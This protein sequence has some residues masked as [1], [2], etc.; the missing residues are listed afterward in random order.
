MMTGFL[1][2]RHL[3][4]LGLF[5]AFFAILYSALR[6]RSLK[7]KRIVLAILSFAGIPAI[8]WYPIAYG[9]LLRFLPLELCSFTALLLPVAVLTG[10]R[11][12]NNVLLL[13]SVGSFCAILLNPLETAWAPGDTEFWM[14]YAPHAAE[15]AVPWLSLALGLLRKD[16]RCIPAALG[17]TFLAYSFSHVCNRLINARFERIGS[18]SRVN[19]MFTEYPE[20]P[21]L[22]ACWRVI[23]AP[24]WYGFVLLPF[25]VLLLIL[26][27]LPEIVR[28]NRNRR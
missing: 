28:K 16:R 12:L 9:D 23:P 24:Y 8:I 26:I 17:S 4:S 1:G 15:A 5:L 27:Y 14:F 18:A 11:T 22:D 7:C 2:G 21:V 20:N 19:Y 25:L 13:W 10:N 3:L 6:K